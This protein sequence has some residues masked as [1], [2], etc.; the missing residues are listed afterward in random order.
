MNLTCFIK[1]LLSGYLFLSIGFWGYSDD[2]EKDI[3]VPCLNKYRQPIELENV[4]KSG[5]WHVDHSVLKRV[6]KCP[7]S[8]D[9]YAVMKINDNSGSEPVAYFT[10][11]SI[12]AWERRIIKSNEFSKA[13][14]FCEFKLPNQAITSTGLEVTANKIKTDKKI[15][16]KSFIFRYQG[17]FPFRKYAEKKFGAPPKFEF[18]QEL[19]IRVVNG[20]Y[21]PYYQLDKVIKKLKC[22][23]YN[24]YVMKYYGKQKVMN[25]SDAQIYYRTGKQRHVDDPKDLWFWKKDF[26]CNVIIIVN[27]SAEGFS[28]KD[29]YYINEFV[30][31]GGVL[32]YLSGPSCLKGN[33]EIGTFFEDL[34]PVD[35]KK[36]PKNWVKAKGI[37]GA[38]LIPEKDFA[39]I[40][41]LPWDKEAQVYYYYQCEPKKGAKVHI[42]AEGYPLLISQNYGKG[43]TF[44]WL[45]TVLGGPD[46]NNPKDSDLKWVPFWE[47]PGWQDLLIKIINTQ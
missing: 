16:I 27:A 30:K 4:T 28:P 6:L 40:K 18:P 26:N 2:S 3:E 45:G 37:T 12:S 46:K 42:S 43:K 35:F 47:W 21:Y 22:K 24:Q 41:E 39:I 8:W 7:G 38:K 10:G 36:I 14:T 1:I 34:L 23:V 32:I 25:E 44:L 13:D 33:Y 15:W 17:G 5:N 11:K 31:Q 19:T 20:L 9:I 29:R